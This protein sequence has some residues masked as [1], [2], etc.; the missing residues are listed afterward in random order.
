MSD[1]LIFPRPPEAPTAPL[2]SPSSPL[3]RRSFAEAMKEEKVEVIEA[4]ASRQVSLLELINA[5]LSD[6]EPPPRERLL[7]LRAQLRRYSSEV[8]V[9]QSLL[10]QLSRARKD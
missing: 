6:Q 9:L 8:N 5:L 3:P 2:R 4:V 10:S 1:T 7:A